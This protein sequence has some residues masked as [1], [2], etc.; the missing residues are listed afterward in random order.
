MIFNKDEIT[1]ILTKEQMQS[2][3]YK[4]ERD[5]QYVKREERYMLFLTQKYLYPNP[6]LKN[7]FLQITKKGFMGFFHKG[8]NNNIGVKEKYKSEKYLLDRFF[9]K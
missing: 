7:H 4:V 1:S 2:I 9:E 5:K 3:E 6:N 8:V